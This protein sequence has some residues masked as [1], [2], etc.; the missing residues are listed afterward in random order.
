MG[1]EVVITC[2]GNERVEFCFRDITTFQ[3]A[4]G[5]PPFS[6]TQFKRYV[7]FAFL[8]RDRHLFLKHLNGCQ[9]DAESVS[10]STSYIS[11]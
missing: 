6:D 2:W 4:A 3:N 5:F 8:A 11:L 1:P 9:S 7:D 10:L